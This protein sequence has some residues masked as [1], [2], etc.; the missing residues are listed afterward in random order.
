MPVYAQTVQLPSESAE[1]ARE[2]REE[3]TRAMRGR[4]R[5]MIKEKN[6]LKGMR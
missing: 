3:L 1:E 6:F 4:R 5:E 2:A